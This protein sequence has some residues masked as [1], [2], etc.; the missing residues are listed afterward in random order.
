[1]FDVIFALALLAAGLY[2]IL[3]VRRDLGR[4]PPD[5][6][7]RP[8]ESKPPPDDKRGPGQRRGG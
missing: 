6:R 8:P 7:R 2:L 3:K 4:R 1:M 5:A